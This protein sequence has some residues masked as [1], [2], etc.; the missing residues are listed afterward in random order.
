VRSPLDRAGN[1]IYLACNVTSPDGWAGILAN[2][3]LGTASDLLV[4]AGGTVLLSETPEIYGAEH[5]LMARAAT[6]DIAQAL[7]ARIRWW[8]NYAGRNGA[9]RDNNSWPGN[10]AGGLTTIFKKSLGTIA[11][12]GASPLNG[13]ALR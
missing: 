1:R 12:A 8:E 6:A 5:L 13:V 9:S 7:E 3:A 11:K 4:A 2:S 10:K